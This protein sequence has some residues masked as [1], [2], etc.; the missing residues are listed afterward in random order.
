[1]VC[2][3]LGLYILSCVGAGASAGILKLTKIRLREFTF[4]AVIDRLNPIL[5][6]MDETFHL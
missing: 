4:F 5:H 3:V 1:M 6:Q 2:A